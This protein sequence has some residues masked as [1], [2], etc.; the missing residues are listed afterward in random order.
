MCALFSTAE[1]CHHVG[2]LQNTI[3]KELAK[4]C[5]V[6]CLSVSLL[7]HED[8]L[9]TIREGEMAH[10]LLLVADGENRIF[11]TESGKVACRAT[12]ETIGDD[13]LDRKRE[14]CLYRLL[15]KV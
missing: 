15:C 12:R 8:C 10:C 7:R 1:V 6:V 9:Y 2:W 11:A 14:C 13:S 3:V 4:G 5:E